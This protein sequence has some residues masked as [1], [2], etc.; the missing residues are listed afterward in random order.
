MMHRSIIIIYQIKGIWLSPM[1]FKNNLVLYIGF[2]FYFSLSYSFS[3]IQCCIYSI[4]FR[5]SL[6]D[7]L[8][9]KLH[10]VSY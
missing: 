3:F 2:S 10:L 4:V 5:I 7:V 9:N 1:G 6:M 8:I